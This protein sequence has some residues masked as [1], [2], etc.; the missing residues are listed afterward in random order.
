MPTF[1]QTIA[2]DS[3][4]QQK[5]IAALHEMYIKN[6]G[7][8]LAVYNGKEYHQEKYS[9][10]GH[11]FFISDSTMLGSIMYKNILYNNVHVQLD[12][13]S[14][15]LIIK[16]EYQ[17]NGLVV[18]SNYIDFFTIAN[19]RFEFIKPIIKTEISTGFYE[20]ITGNQA[21]LYVKRKK[22]FEQ[23]LKAEDNTTKYITTSQ[24]YVKMNTHFYEISS[25]K[26]LL[27]LLVNKKEMLEQFIN[28]NKI[29]FNKDVESAFEKTISYY[30]K[31]NYINETET[32]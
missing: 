24:Y 3:L 15:I 7:A 22:T 6:M 14:D 16:D 26:T 1:A 12:I 4:L 13:A 20:K 32:N 21:T 25:K 18:Q 9:T 2:A 11:P 5:S 19:H 28:Q 30:N 10:I 27:R 29:N 31:I 23:A 17:N 8:N